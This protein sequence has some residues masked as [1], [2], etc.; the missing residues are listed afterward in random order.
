M[1][2]SELDGVHMH[3]AQSSIWSR[4]LRLL[5]Q[6]YT[7]ISTTLL[8]ILL[9]AN[10]IQ[11]RESSPNPKPQ[12]RQLGEIESALYSDIRFMTLD[13]NYD[14]LWDQFPPQAQIMLKDEVVEDQDVIP[15]AFSM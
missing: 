7:P 15:G 13:H 4:T 6:I 9:L 1:S 5:A 3:K 11:W 2:D 12:V 10:L 14:Y 8:C